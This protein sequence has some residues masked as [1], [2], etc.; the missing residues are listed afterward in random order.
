MASK[1]SNLWEHREGERKELREASSRSARNLQL[2]KLGEDE[3]R[4]SR[5]CQCQLE[6]LSVSP[7]ASAEVSFLRAV[8]FYY[9]ISIACI[10]LNPHQFRDKTNNWSRPKFLQ[11]EL[12]N[13]LSILMQG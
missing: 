8:F 1:I 3:G 4:V 11:N 7:L 13:T 12:V 2:R 5:P 9:Y 10:R 6:A